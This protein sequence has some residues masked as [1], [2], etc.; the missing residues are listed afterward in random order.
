MLV[1][2]M[3]EMK[4]YLLS[5]K[6]QRAYGFMLTRL[7]N[8]SVLRIGPFDE[9]NFATLTDVINESRASFPIVDQ[10]KNNTYNLSDD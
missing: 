6:N 5:K 1:L 7:Q 2:K 9:L 10:S 8:G 4:W 3:H